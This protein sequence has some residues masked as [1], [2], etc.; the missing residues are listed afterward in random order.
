MD[1]QT[2]APGPALPAAVAVAVGV[3]A[4]TL[5]AALLLSSRRQ[6]RGTSPSPPPA[7]GVYPD[8]DLPAF[9]QHPPGSPG[10]QPVRA[11]GRSPAAPAQAA[12]TSPVRA[13]VAMA[14]V[15][16]LLVT[17]VAVVAALGRPDPPGSDP[18][19]RRSAAALSPVAGTQARVAFSG[20]VLEQRAVG[21]TATYPSLQLTT[22][23]GT[24]LA[25]VELPTWNC[26]A[27][28]APDDPAVAGCRA[29]VPE[30]AD[31]P[32]P[33]LQ[34]GRDGTALRVHGRFPTYTR[35]NGTPPVFTGRAYEL[36]VTLR[37]GRQ[38]PGGWWT[39]SGELVLGADR[40]AT[41]DDDAQSVM[42]SGG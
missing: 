5:G 37:P 42:R 20:I 19:P 12:G 32:T 21:I 25:A 34:V 38:L 7:P 36:D 27:D 24:A 9:R 26:M 23:G 15:A 30:Y 18:A 39:A 17:A 16:L 22:T 2:A 33:A 14:V 28:E 11:G 31:L 13:L 4:L 41:L 40:A 35:P 3:L 8:D 10:A 6:S 29:A 1:V